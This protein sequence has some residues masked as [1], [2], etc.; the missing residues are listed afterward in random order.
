MNLNL[1]EKI[2]EDLSLIYL[3]GKLL[4]AYHNSSYNYN[5]IEIKANIKVFLIEGGV[6]PT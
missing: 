2:T 5:N 3:M 4:T 1:I 6:F